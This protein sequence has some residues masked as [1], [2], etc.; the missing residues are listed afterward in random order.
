M[1]AMDANPRKTKQEYIMGAKHHVSVDF[2]GDSWK[3]LNDRG[4]VVEL[5]GENEKFA[6]YELLLSALS[7]CLFMTYESILEKMQISVKKTNF[8]VRGEKRDEKVATLKVCQ[9][10]V[11]I[12]GA[13]D[14]S[15][16][17]KAVDIASRYCSI[18]QTLSKVADMS[19]EVEFTD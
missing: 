5:G 16:A 2:A 4:S 12:S 14:E 17:K 8:D 3:A 19:W 15:K 7:G 1:W 13:E 6:P 10:K 9:V 18:Y 11:T